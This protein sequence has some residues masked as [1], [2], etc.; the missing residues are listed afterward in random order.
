MRGEHEVDVLWLQ[1]Q[2]RQLRDDI[3]AVFEV[4]RLDIP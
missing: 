3:P 4:R 2:I 1:T